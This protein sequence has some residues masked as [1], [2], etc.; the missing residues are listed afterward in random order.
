[1]APAVLQRTHQH[2]DQADARQD[3]D[4]HVECGD[5]PDLITVDDID[6]YGHDHAAESPSRAGW[7]RAIASRGGTR[8]LYGV[9]RAGL[10]RGS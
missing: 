5:P 9:D 6:T 4:R 3:D 2:S 1:M 10:R 8:G 7:W